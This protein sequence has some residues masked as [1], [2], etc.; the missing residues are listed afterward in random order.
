MTELWELL[1]VSKGLPPSDLET[2]LEARKIGNKS[3]GSSTE[4]S[5]ANGYPCTLKNSAGLPVIDYKIYGNTVEEKS[6]G[7]PVFA[8]LYDSDGVRL[9]D[10]EGYALCSQDVAEYRIPVECRGKNLLKFYSYDNTKFHN[11]V[12][13]T[14]DSIGTLT[15]NGTTTGNTWVELLYKFGGNTEYQYTPILRLRK[16]SEYTL[17]SAVVSGTATENRLFS[18]GGY[19]EETHETKNFICYFGRTLTFN[20]EEYLFDRLFLSLG[21]KGVTYNNLKIRLQLELGS[22]ATEFEPCHDPA[23]TNIYL[24]KPLKTGDILKY[25]ENVIEYSDGTSES[26]SLPKIPT[27]RGTTVITT[28]T[29]IQPSNMEITYKSRR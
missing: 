19:I 26:V 3:S 13:I 18:L 24:A 6:V 23:T 10:S 22:E 8:K 16:N 21:A 29:E 15:I 9:L 4:V 28:D 5:T 20:T 2:L 7:E 11:G 14:I 1:K 17:S 27:L 25:P 12:T